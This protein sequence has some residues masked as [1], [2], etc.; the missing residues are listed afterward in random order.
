MRSQVVNA[1]MAGIIDGEGHFHM[2]YHPPIRRYYFTVGV[3]NTNRDLLDWLVDNFSG[4]VYRHK[5]KSHKDEWK[6]C[7]EW[8]LNQTDILSAL[9]AILPFLKIKKRQAELAIEFRKTF[10]KENPGKRGL[11]DHIR[12]KR[13]DI[14]LEL[15]SINRKGKTLLDP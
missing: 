4:K 2:Y 7:W 13:D 14:M 1:Y 5:P 15:K 9:P 10:A 11:P 8:R 3:A 6:D 12:R